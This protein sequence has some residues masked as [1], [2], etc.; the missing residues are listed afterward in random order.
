MSIRKDIILFI[1][2]FIVISL[3]YLIGVFLAAAVA[4]YIVSKNNEKQSEVVEC[5]TVEVCEVGIK[6]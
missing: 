6:P 3:S 5:D 2:D 4:Y 1:R